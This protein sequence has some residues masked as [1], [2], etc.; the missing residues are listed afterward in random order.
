V[1]R[2]AVAFSLVA[3]SL[4]SGATAVA[5]DIKVAHD[6]P[7]CFPANG[8]GKVVAK[9]TSRNA[10]ASARI[11][12]RS[13]AHAAEPEYF[14]EMRRS[15]T[16]V[17]AAL[18]IPVV[19]TTSIR[20]SIVVRDSEDQEARTAEQSISV[21]PECPLVLS[22]DEKRYAANLIVG[23]TAAN[24]NSAPR[25]FACNGVVSQLTVGGNLVPNEDCARLVA[26]AAANPSAVGTASGSV[27]IVSQG[28]IVAPDAG[29]AGAGP[30]S[31]VRPG[32][33]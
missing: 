4:G 17:W 5:S 21:R 33:K 19:E 28:G 15:G 24:Q 25:G 29:G 18:P 11:Y 8:N 9:V 1:S 31:Q 20:Y 13:N 30:I 16:D 26:A 6:A 7:R 32:P 27:S 22:E 10:L 2:A 12:F 23:M 14:L 3:L